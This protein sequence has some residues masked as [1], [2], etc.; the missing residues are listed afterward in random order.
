MITKCTLESPKFKEYHVSLL[1]CFVTKVVLYFGI[2]LIV[3]T[4]SSVIK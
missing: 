2:I 4:E 1:L 3:N